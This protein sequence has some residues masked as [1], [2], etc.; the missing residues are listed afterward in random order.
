MS[1]TIRPSANALASLNQALA[2]IGYSKTAP[3]HERHTLLAAIALFSDSN[4]QPEISA[5]CKDMM[6]A[7]REE[8]TGSQNLPNGY[9][10]MVFDESHY[11]LGRRKTDGLLRPLD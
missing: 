7:I 10:P 9:T 4:G 5:A 1:H 6:D 2:A 8:N 3:A 11:Y